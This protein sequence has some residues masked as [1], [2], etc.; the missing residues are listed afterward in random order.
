MLNAPLTEC[1]LDPE[2]HACTAE[3][4]PGKPWRWHL[5]QRLDYQRL[6]RRQLTSKNT[7]GDRGEDEVVEH[8][9]GVLEQVGCVEAVPDK[10]PK[11]RDCPNDIFV[12][13]ATC[14]R[15]QG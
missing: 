11:H 6:P 13:E 7:D 4:R 14:Q 15:L 8:N 9:V 3:G 1:T 10:K 5:D 2:F 12:E